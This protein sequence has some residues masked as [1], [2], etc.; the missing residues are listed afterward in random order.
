MGVGDSVVSSPRRPAKASSVVDDTPSAAQTPI[1]SDSNRLQ[2]DVEELMKRCRSMNSVEEQLSARAN[3]TEEC[4]TQIAV[5]VA[6]LADIVHQ[7]A[8]KEPSNKHSPSR[9]EKRS[10]NSDAKSEQLA[11]SEVDVLTA[12]R[13]L[14]E[15][16]QVVQ[17]LS[18]ALERVVQDV[19]EERKASSL[20]RA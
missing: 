5:K 19:A 11:T 2:S 10:T 15:L 14:D 18:D 4:L 13:H 9:T 7:R 3:R 17:G 8:V 12:V 20:L 1:A 16:S 6:E